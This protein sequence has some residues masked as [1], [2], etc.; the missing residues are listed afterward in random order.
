MRVLFTLPGQP[1]RFKVESEV[2]WYDEKGRAGL[3][4]L[5]IPSEQ[6]CTLQQWLAIK[7]EEALPESVARQFQ[8]Q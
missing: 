7:L 6:K 2:C 4:S 8:K 1:A 3:R 5:M